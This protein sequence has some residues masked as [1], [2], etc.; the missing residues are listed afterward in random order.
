MRNGQVWSS[1]GV[2]L[3]FFK[4]RLVIETAEVYWEKVSEKY[5]GELETG[6]MPNIADAKSEATLKMDG[7]EV[8]AMISYGKF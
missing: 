8:Q 6:N 1:D 5:L 2:S 4:D 7:I 3:F